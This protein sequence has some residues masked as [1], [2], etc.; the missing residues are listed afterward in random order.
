MISLGRAGLNYI[1]YWNK[2]VAF[3]RSRRGLFWQSLFL[4]LLLLAPM[5]GAV[6]FFSAQRAQQQALRQAAAAQE[7]VKEPAGS[8]TTMRILV[9][10]Q[11]E[12]PAFLL[13][14]VDAPARTITFCGI[15]GGT[16]VSAPA[17]ETTLAEC[18]MAAGP[19]RAAQLL[20]DT[21]GMAPDFYFA[22]T[23][24]SCAALAGEEVA[25]RLDTAGLLTSEQRAGLGYGAGT[26]DTVAELSAQQ[27]AE[28]LNG[29][30]LAGL[31]D[32]VT[33]RLRA[34]VWAAFLRQNPSLLG[35][36]A[37]NMRA[38]SART[39]TDLSAQ[40]LYTLQDALD[41][42]AGQTARTVEYTLMPGTQRRSGAY[43][44]D[45]ASLETAQAMLG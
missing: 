19:A 24:S 10:V 33:A 8:R 37:D 17:G 39:L 27:A 4:T 38:V 29:A 9:A 44:L 6:A 14:R 41:Y 26:Q 43:A 42:L 23:Q 35:S 45:G 15:P 13:C 32:A 21:L 34:A 25:I 30:Q 40:D 18:Y 1:Q 16:V 20:A 22:G 36:V 12:E 28:F 31:G 5:V 2:G 7:G 11:G 3:M